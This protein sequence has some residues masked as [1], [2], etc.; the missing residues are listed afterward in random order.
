MYNWDFYTVFQ[1]FDLF[2]H[3]LLTTFLYTIGSIGFG[4]VIGLV[5]AFARLSK[6]RLLRGAAR[7]YQEV[8]RC[9][10]LLVQIM[11]AYYA[12]PMLLGISIPNWIA[13]LATLSLYVGSFY[14]E[15]FRGGIN[16]IDKGQRE[17]AMAVGMS[18]GQAMR[19]IIMPQAVKKMLPAFINQSVIQVKNTSLLYAISIAELT[20]MTYIVNSE[21]YRP[22]ESYS[23]AA[24]MYFAMLFPLTQFADYFERRM[25]RSD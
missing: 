8:F 6:W 11:W 4:I 7:T 20:Y 10:P 25:R 5:T 12:L 24:I 13:G 2:W 9:T 18:G 3:G 19:H 15:I 17:A 1:S 21:T 23:I 16:A 14:G 22:L